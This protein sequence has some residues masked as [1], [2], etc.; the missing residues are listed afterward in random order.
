M[1]LALREDLL[2]SSSRQTRRNQF[3]YFAQVDGCW[4]SAAIAINSNEGAPNLALDGRRRR[5][6]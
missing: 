2:D 4:Q 5:A 3:L 6:G 1:Y